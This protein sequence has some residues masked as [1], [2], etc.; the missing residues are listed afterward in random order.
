MIIESP[1][2]HKFSLEPLGDRIVVQPIQAE[3]QTQSGI[4][5]PEVAREKTNQATVIAAGPGLF[6]SGVLVAN[7]IKAGDVIL[8]GKYS[9]TEIKVEGQNY[10]VMRESEVLA[11]IRDIDAEAK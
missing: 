1:S 10:I 11:I 3:A 8:L 2:K 5:I 4:F 6:Q 9:G 7:S